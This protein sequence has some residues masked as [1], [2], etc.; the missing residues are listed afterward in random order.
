MGGAPWV[1][2]HSSSIQAQHVRPP[3]AGSPSPAQ[4]PAPRPN[5]LEAVVDQ[6]ADQALLGRLAAVG[7]G[8]RLL[9]GLHRRVANCGDRED[10]QDGTW[11]SKNKRHRR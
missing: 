2:L 10:K 8:R 5:S 4:H 6:Q 1:H 7:V 3:A 9:A 11:H